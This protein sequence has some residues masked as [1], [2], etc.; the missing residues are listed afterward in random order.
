VILFSIE[1]KYEQCKTK[2]KTKKRETIRTK[3]A[4]LQKRQY[5][6]QGNMLWNRQHHIGLHLA[7]KM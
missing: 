6:V 1:Y 7:E 2:V 4:I 5:C 3:R